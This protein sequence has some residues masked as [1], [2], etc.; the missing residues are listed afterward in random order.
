M[1]L[2]NLTE[3]KKQILKHIKSEGVQSNNL[4]SISDMYSTRYAIEKLSLT[5]V[6]MIVSDEPRFAYYVNEEQLSKINLL[7]RLKSGVPLH[8]DY[9]KPVE[10]DYVF[11]YP[12]KKTDDLKD[13]VI[14]YKQ[15]DVVANAIKEHEEERA[16][17]KAKNVELSARYGFVQHSVMEKKIVSIDFEFD[18]NGKENIFDF[19]NI[20]EIGFTVYDQGVMTAKHYLIEENRKESNKAFLQD[21]FSF[22][23][24]EWIK[25]SDIDNLLRDVVAD[26][27]VLLVHGYSSEIKF[28]EFNNIDISDLE[29]YDTQLV[30]KHYFD[31]DQPNM[32]RLSHMLQHFDIPYTFLHNAGNDAYLTFSVFEKMI[33]TIPKVLEKVKHTSPKMF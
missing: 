29:V 28:L 5:E 31:N 15:I 16:I 33:D 25:I 9:L 7:A 26:N 8:F 12:V 24:S 10:A 23:E 27:E 32:K 20:S 3:V 14:A 2:Y 21:K 30:F 13:A 6:H 1:K 18:P 11:T 19:E 22:G 4:K 17:R